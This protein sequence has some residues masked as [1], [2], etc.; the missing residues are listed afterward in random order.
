MNDG[1]LEPIGGL[2][3]NDS[4]RFLRVCSFLFISFRVIS[5]SILFAGSTTLFLNSGDRGS[6]VFSTGFA[7]VLAVAFAVAFAA[8]SSFVAL[9][10][11]QPV[12]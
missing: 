4:R 5:G 9:P 1:C 3:P 6:A 10:E 7:A 11:F 2:I 8:A 12:I